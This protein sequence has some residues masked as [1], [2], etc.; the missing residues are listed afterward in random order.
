MII[1]QQLRTRLETV[2][3]HLRRK[4]AE[5]SIP[6]LGS[7]SARLETALKGK[8]PATTN[9]AVEPRVA[10]AF[11]TAAVEIWMRAVHS[12][13]VSASLT[14][15]SPIWA[16][17]CGYYSSHYS[18]RALAHLLGYFQLYKRKRIVRLE[19]HGGKYVCWFDPK[20]IHDREHRFYWKIVKRDQHFAADPLFSDNNPEDDISDVGHRDRANYA[21][22][23][24]QLAK[25]RALD[26]ETLK[27]RVQF[28]SEIMFTSPPIPRRSHFP[29][30]EAVQVVAYQ[31]VVRF[32]QFLDAILGGSNRF[33]SFHRNPS[34]ADGMIDFQLSEQGTLGSLYN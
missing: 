3:A 8:Q 18:V 1:D 9:V 11:M 4:G 6:P 2:F 24:G 7:L 16:S 14:G 31:R 23:V 15:A 26:V 33:W 13:L 34:W 29:D 20:Q 28:I 12:F 21:D 30:V 25:F 27:R 17:S 10:V 22:H 19:L 5:Q 32:R